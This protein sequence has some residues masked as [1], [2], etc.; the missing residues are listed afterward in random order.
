MS[1]TQAVC[2][3]FFNLSSEKSDHTRTVRDLHRQ[4]E[5]RRKCDPG[6]FIS[7]DQQ[8]HRHGKQISSVEEFKALYRLGVKIFAE[9]HIVKQRDTICNIFY[10]ALVVDNV[11]Q[12]QL[13]Q[14]DYLTFAPQLE[15]LVCETISDTKHISGIDWTQ[16]SETVGHRSRDKEHTSGSEYLFQIALGLIVC[17]MLKSLIE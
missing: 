4:I 15:D 2:K 8:I 16:L 11:A 10:V 6:R 3:S 14:K 13:S 9:Y 1:Y 5:I 17:K 7:F 12:Q